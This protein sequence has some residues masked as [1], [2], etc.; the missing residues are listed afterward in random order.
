MGSTGYHPRSVIRAGRIR[1][2]GQLVRPASGRL[3]WESWTLELSSGNALAGSPDFSALPN[4]WTAHRSHGER[5]LGRLRSR[6][7]QDLDD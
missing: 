3:R 2:I 6:L 1:L 4:V 7:L 5:Q